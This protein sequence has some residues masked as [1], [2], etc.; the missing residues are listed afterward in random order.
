MNRREFH[1]S[2]GISNKF[3]S[4]ELQEL[5]FI[6]HY[7]KIGTQGQSQEKVFATAELAVKEHDK[8]IAEKTKKGYVEVQ[9]GQSNTPR[10]VPVVKN[11]EEEKKTK[12]A[13]Q[14]DKS[15]TIV[16][17]DSIEQINLP[18]QKNP[19]ALTIERCV[20]LP[21]SVR[22]RISW[23]WQPLERPALR[24]FDSESFMRSAKKW[25][26]SYGRIDVSKV[27]PPNHISEQE[28]W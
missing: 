7:G 27:T 19:H 3:W 5:S 17:P 8:L 25:L 24:K 10:P 26:T 12:L 28:A 1:F 18:P 11:V 20:R 13:A 15:Q 23:L 4:I 14:E 21:Q 9:S 22:N 16:A 6:V 2:E